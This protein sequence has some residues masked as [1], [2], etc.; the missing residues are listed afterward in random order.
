M[1]TLTHARTGIWIDELEAVVVRWDGGATVRR[2]VS[3]VPAHH[4]STGHVRHDPTVR[5]GGGGV[6]DDRFERDRL[7]HLRAHLSAVA[8]VVPADD[9]LEVLGPGTVHEQLARLIAADDRHHGRTRRV[10]ATASGP[11]TERQ[12]IARVRD[13]A[14]DPARRRGLRTG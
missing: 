4:R 3:D 5:Q 11:L 10:R 6:P 13:L 9:D 14:G 2:V 7:G 12:L 1:T 8:A